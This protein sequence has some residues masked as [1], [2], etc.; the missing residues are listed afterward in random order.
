MQLFSVYDC[1]HPIWQQI[2]SLKFISALRLF[3]ATGHLIND[4]DNQL[5]PQQAKT[6][7]Y[8]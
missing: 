7:V 2:I 6:L 8:K 4:L 1:C 5:L 3:S